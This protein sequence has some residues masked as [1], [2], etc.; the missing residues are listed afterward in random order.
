MLKT[1]IKIALAFLVLPFLWHWSSRFDWIRRLEEST[2]QLRYF[3][4]TLFLK[5]L[6]SYLPPVLST[7][8]ASTSLP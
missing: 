5:A 8:T 7:L 1:T 6:L 3:L 4:P 2:L